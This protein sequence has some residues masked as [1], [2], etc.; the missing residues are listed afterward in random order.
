MK[1]KLSTV[2]GT[3]LCALVLSACTADERT[4]PDSPEYLSDAVITADNSQEQEELKRILYQ[5]FEDAE[6]KNIEA[7]KA[8]HLVTPKFS[9][10]G[11]RV[12]HRQN[13]ESTNQSEAVFFS[14]VDKLKVEI[15][16][17]KVDVFGNVAIV[18]FYADSFVTYG[19]EVKSGSRR[20]T[21]VFA[22]T[23]DGWKIVHEHSSQYSES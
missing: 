12:P 11:P 17:P 8:S 4:I 3:F 13:A 18:T 20:G 15:T 2:G 5:I 22:R 16:D 9:K 14:S 1:N 6:N 21:L 23:K 10:F 19:T 7:L